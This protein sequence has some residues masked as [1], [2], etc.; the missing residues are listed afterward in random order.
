MSPLTHTVRILS[1]HQRSTDQA[2]LFRI[3]PGSEPL[4]PHS[5]LHATGNIAGLITG[6]Y[7]SGD[8]IHYMAEASSG[9]V[10]LKNAL[11]NHKVLGW[12]VSVVEPA[13]AEG[14]GPE[15]HYQE[16]PERIG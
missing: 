7:G 3:T 8:Q 5:V 13:F 6:R 11:E 10:G 12:P 14:R 4:K 16:H 9:V 2:V 15:P 1:V